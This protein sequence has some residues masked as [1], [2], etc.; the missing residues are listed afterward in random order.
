VDCI[1]VPQLTE[2]PDRLLDLGTGAGFPGVPLKIALP[3]K[4]IILAEGVQKKVDYLKE[5]REHLDLKGLDIIGRKVESK[6]QY[7]VNGVITR[8][9]EVVE[10][11]LKNVIHC[12]QT[13]GRVIFMKT[14]DID[15]EM[16]IA[17]KSMGEYFELIE[18]KK[19]QLGNTSH[20]RR[21]VVYKKI[22][23]LEAG[24]SL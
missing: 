19:Y 24:K 22:K 15:V 18:D 4:K 20:K 12:L 3:E 14:P 1:Y 2:I 23:S 10:S 6:M 17:R 7:P 5:L 21:L 16:E 13:N 11:T 9:V 8:A